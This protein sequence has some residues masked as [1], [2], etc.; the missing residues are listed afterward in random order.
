MQVPLEKRE[1]HQ[2]SVTPC[3]RSTLSQGSVS[4]DSGEEVDA[5]AWAGSQADSS[6]RSECLRQRLSYLL[7]QQ[8][9]ITGTKVAISCFVFLFLGP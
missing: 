4:S 2:R 6:A 5:A 8:T 1:P 7:S 3:V 9:A